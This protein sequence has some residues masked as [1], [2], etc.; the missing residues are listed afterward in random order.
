MPGKRRRCRSLH[1]FRAGYR[2]QTRLGGDRSREFFGLL[3]DEFAPPVGL[4]GRHR[5]ILHL[6]QRLDLRRDDLVD[7]NGKDRA[8][9]RFG[10]SARLAFIGRKGELQHI[11]GGD[12]Q[13]HR[14]L[15]G[16]VAAD[17]D[18]L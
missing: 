14:L 11:T 18:C 12:R 10:N 5:L 2:R 15:L 13:G 1:S 3:G 17:V 9:R 7:M 6:V 4:P 16:I 8:V